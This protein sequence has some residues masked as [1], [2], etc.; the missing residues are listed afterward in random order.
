MADW[1]TYLAGLF[2]T[3]PGLLAGLSGDTSGILGPNTGIPPQGLLSAAM[4][5]AAPQPQESQSL[6]G[7]LNTGQPQTNSPQFGQSG[8]TRGIGAPSMTSAPA[9]TPPTLQGQNEAPHADESGNFWSRNNSDGTQ[10]ILGGFLKYDPAR[11]TGRNNRMGMIGATL[12]DMGANIGGHPEAAK[13]LALFN[14]NQKKL[15]GQK[16]LADVFT[17][18]APVTPGPPALQAPPRLADNAPGQLPQLPPSMPATHSGQPPSQPYNTGSASMSGGGE[19]PGNLPMIAPRQPQQPAQQQPQPFDIRSLAPKLAAM[20]AAGVDISPVLSILKQAQ[21]DYSTDIQYTHDNRPYVLDHSGRVKFLDTE[22]VSRPVKLAVAG[23]GMS[24]DENS[25]APGTDF[26]DRGKPFNSATGAPNLPVQRFEMGKAL[27]PAQLRA[28]VDL[29]RMNQDS[30]QPPVQIGFSGTDGEEKQVAASWN[31]KIG[32]YVDVSTG[33][34]ITSTPNLRV[35]GNATG[36]GRSMAMAGRVSTAALDAATDIENLSG[37]GTG[38][39][40]GL[41]ANVTTT[42]LAALS[43]KLTPQEVQDTQTTMAG[44]SRAMSLLGSGGMQGSDTVMKSFDLLQPN[45]GDSMLTTM[46]KLGSFRQQAGNGIDAALA[47]PMYSP[48]QKKQLQE[49][50]AKIDA[51]VPWTPHDVQALENKGQN[52]TS[53]REV[54]AAKLANGNPPSTAGLPRIKQPPSGTI[55]GVKW[56]LVA[57]GG[58]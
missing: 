47:S 51:A 53:M 13:N 18:L 42:P 30:L 56:K 33:Q 46:R 54:F 41:F 7:P 14:E 4:G 55:S 11:D 28:S 31:R 21:P 10:D 20:A 36:G 57:P 26:S 1:N 23:N 32:K 58:Q 49:A 9:W 52:G 50:K 22:G 39:G 40:M 16:A 43:R 38:A 44:L 37:I 45:T 29:A 25:T 27:A 15:A 8:M 24:Y 5:P 19:Y 6:L 12:A 2:K 48:S 35:I 3:N 17:S 34:P